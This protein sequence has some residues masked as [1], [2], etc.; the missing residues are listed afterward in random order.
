MKWFTPSTME[1]LAE[2]LRQCG[3]GGQLVAGGTDYTISTTTAGGRGFTAVMVSWL[4]KFNPIVMTLTSFLIVFLERGAGEIATTFQLNESV[5][6]IL[7]GI[8]LFFIIIVYCVLKIA[9][10]CTT[11]STKVFIF[12]AFFSTIRTNHIFYSP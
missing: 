12:S 10:F 3:P 4:A 9:Y 8:I 11:F 6:A 1:E 7:T 2:A 5:S